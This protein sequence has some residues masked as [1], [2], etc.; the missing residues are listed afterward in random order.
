MGMPISVLARGDGAWS[1]DAA[2]QVEQVFAE[3]RDVDARFSLYREDSEVSR[4]SR[5]EMALE[6]CH[7]DLRDVAARCARATADTGGL[8][9]PTTPLG[10]WD[11]SG[12]VK[13]WAAERA[14]R[15]LHEGVDWCLNAGGDVAVVAPSGRPFGVGIQDPRDRSAVLTT[16][17]IAK[18]AVATSGT[19][20]R[21][22]HL[23]DP[24]S[25]SA[26]V[27]AWLSVSITGPSLEQADVLA[28]AACV[29]GSGWERL[30]PA[31]YAGLA[32]DLEGRLH[33]SAGWPP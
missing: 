8:F 22:Q 17:Q 30:L 27:A 13:G 6:D 16:L 29:A 26:S 5:G 12:L 1:D 33:A 9:D 31:G 7:P 2:A 20:A 3:L 23:Y 21:G 32:V 18:G 14:T 24:R 15:H 28:T 10:V 11:P 4:L 25:G 19:A